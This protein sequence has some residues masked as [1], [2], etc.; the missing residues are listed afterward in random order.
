M[1]FIDR[2]AESSPD[3]ADKEDLGKQLP[4]LPSASSSDPDE[5][6]TVDGVVVVTERR[7]NQIK[8]G[9]GDEEKPSAKDDV[10]RNLETMGSVDGDIRPHPATVNPAASG[11][12]SN[13]EEEEDGVEIDNIRL[14][15]PSAGGSDDDE[16][17]MSNGREVAAAKTYSNIM[18][19]DVL[20]PA[21]GHR[22]E[23]NEIRAQVQP[24]DKSVSTGT[25]SV[26][27]EVDDETNDIK[28]RPAGNRAKAPVDV[29]D[30]GES[31]RSDEDDADGTNDLPVHRSRS[32]QN[33]ETTRDVN[34]PFPSTTTDGA[35]SG[36][37]ED[38]T[39]DI[40]PDLSSSK[41]LEESAKTTN[42]IN[43]DKEEE[44]E[45]DTADNEIEPF[46]QQPDHSRLLHGQTD[47]NPALLDTS[48]GPSTVL[49]AIPNAVV[50]K[51]GRCVSL[52]KGVAMIH[53]DFIIRV[54]FFFVSFQDPMAFAALQSA[55]RGDIRM[56]R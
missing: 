2:T 49:P 22:V 36:D 3:A 6:D 35:G 45:D 23:A 34:E 39:N 43:L 1:D 47:L 4:A 55:G 10:D 37:A 27:S 40:L 32:N 41:T 24:E 26:S 8:G 31:V 19:K 44:E 17:E 33:K 15:T 11:I 30:G 9:E 16:T 29:D 28:V 52:G 25:A 46:V 21:V 53:D 7:P 42:R 12:S 13:E 20:L 50:A 56:P 51:Y 54:V 14:D 38:E 5:K 48:C 18:D